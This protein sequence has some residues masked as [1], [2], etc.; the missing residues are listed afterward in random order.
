[1]SMYIGEALVG[2]GN[3]V[4]VRVGSTV[5]VGRGDEIRLNPPHPIRKRVNPNIQKTIFLV[6]ASYFA[7]S[8]GRTP[9]SK[10]GR[11]SNPLLWRTRNSHEIASGCRPRNDIQ[12]LERMIQIPDNAQSLKREPGRDV[13]NHR[14]FLGN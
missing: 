7:L 5:G 2:E 12:F 11:R 13:F 1:M 4:V 10:R 6:I 8:G 14:G 9:K 3:G